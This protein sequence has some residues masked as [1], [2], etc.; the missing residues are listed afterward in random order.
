[1]P[2]PPALQDLALLVARLGLGVILIAHGWQKVVGAGLAATARDL[3]ADGVPAPTLVAYYSAIVE[4]LG[5][6]ALILGLTV[7]IAGVLVA[8]D[9]AIGFAFLPAPGRVFVDQ[10]GF[11]LVLSIGAGALVLAAC[12]AGRISLDALYA[13]NRRARRA[14]TRT[15]G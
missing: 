12:G 15:S 13:G 4:L 1:M 3:A 9:M 8:V 2:M 11:E 14:R 5:G 10:G 7:A 6:V